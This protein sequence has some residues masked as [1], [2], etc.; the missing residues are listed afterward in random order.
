MMA[1]APGSWLLIEP[2]CKDVQRGI[3]YEQLVVN[4]WTSGSNYQMQSGER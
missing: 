2:F 1:E 4:K 3:L